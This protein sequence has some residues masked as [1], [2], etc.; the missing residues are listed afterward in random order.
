MLGTILTIAFVIAA[1]LVLKA[2][3][4]ITW[5]IVGIL[6]AVALV[7]FQINM[8]IIASVFVICLIIFLV[9]KYIETLKR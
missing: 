9:Y 3:I 5:T 7:L 1:A 6:V 2:F 4:G 8:D